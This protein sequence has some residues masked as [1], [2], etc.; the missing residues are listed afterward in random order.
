MMRVAKFRTELICT[1]LLVSLGVLAACGGSSTPAAAP[2]DEPA[3]QEPGASE[4]AAAESADAAGKTFDEMTPPERMNLM[5]TKVVPEM[6]VAFQ[7]FDKDEFEK[8]TCSTCHGPGAKNGD[9]GMPT[10]SL[11]A[12]DKDE[13]DKHPEMTKFMME[14]VVPQMASILGEHPYNPETQQGFGCFN[15]HTKKD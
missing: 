4:P 9:F 12:L 11:P 10:K 13:M 7:N 3:A 5:K 6:T 2:A 15:C 14:V 1:G 8:V